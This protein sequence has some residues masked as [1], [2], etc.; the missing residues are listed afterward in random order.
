MIKIRRATPNDS[1][2]VFRLSQNLA[3]SFKVNKIAFS[4]IYLEIIEEK[5]TSLFVAELKNEIIGYCLAF[6]HFAFYANGNVTWIEEIMVDEKHRSKG[7]GS[8]LIRETEEL[9]KLQGSKLISLAT[10]RASDFYKKIGYEESA[11]Y[12]R[13]I[14]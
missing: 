4:K 3:T 2:N 1:P 13:K 5:N 6:H 11:S 12:F 7:V 14:L 8:Q 10:R 9:A